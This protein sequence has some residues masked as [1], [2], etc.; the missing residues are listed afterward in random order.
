ML[1]RDLFA[2]ANR[3]NL[4]LREQLLLVVLLGLQFKGYAEMFLVIIQ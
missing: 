2:V 3:V 1:T 4:F